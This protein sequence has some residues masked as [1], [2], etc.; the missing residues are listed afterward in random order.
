MM[1][2]GHMGDRPNGDNRDLKALIEVLAAK[3]GW[4]HEHRE[5]GTVV[6][7]GLCFAGPAVRKPVAGRNR[8]WQR[9]DADPKIC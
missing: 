2:N 4:R 8:L 7:E 6:F 5:V 1:A 3:R 9:H